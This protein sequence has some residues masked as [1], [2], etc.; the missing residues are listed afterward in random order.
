MSPQ[1]TRSRAPAARLRRHGPLR[2]WPVLT[3]VDKAP[4]P[5]PLVMGT[6]P[7]TPAKVRVRTRWQPAAMPMFPIEPA[8]DPVQR[9]DDDDQASMTLLALILCVTLTI[10]RLGF[11]L[12][13]L[14]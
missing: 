14:Q 11:G 2:P 4:P 8:N 7:P 13:V 10:A 3:V 5:K 1:P 12:Q 9:L 6:L